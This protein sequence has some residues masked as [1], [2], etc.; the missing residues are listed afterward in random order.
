MIYLILSIVLTII[1]VIFLIISYSSNAANDREI[2]STEQII[3]ENSNKWKVEFAKHLQRI[4]TAPCP[5]CST[6]T[7]LAEGIEKEVR[8]FETEVEGFLNHL[9][10]TTKSYTR[11]CPK[12]QKTIDE[13]APLEEWKSEEISE[14]RA[15]EGNESYKIVQIHQD[16]GWI[17]DQFAENNLD[18]HD[19]WNFQPDSML[20]NYENKLKNLNNKAARLSRLLIAGWIFVPLGLVS[21]FFWIIL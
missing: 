10:L 17:F 18:K 5:V 8:T 16:S 9:L 6:H 20:I 12:C 14:K 11:Y 2:E 21:F 13:P 19:R 3:A 1:G 7:I 15:L 4:F